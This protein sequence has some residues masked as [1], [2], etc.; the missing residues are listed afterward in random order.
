M[1]RYRKDFSA[2]LS[3]SNSN[4]TK[5]RFLRLFIL[6]MIL[7]VVVLPTETYALYRNSVVPLVPYSWDEV[8]GPD[9]NTFEFYPSGGTV[10]FDRWVQIALGFAIFPFFGLGQDAKKMYRSWLLKTGCGRIFPCLYNH[11]SM[12]H[13]Q[14]S[15]TSSR[16]NSLGSRVRL[17]FHKKQSDGSMLSS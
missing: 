12:K 7:I 16:P 10:V 14:S 1:R 17:F 2:V 13:S 11:P 15:L 3:S 5:S 9:W 4:M 6:S 8:H